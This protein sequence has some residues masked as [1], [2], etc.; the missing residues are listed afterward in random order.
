M[1]RAKSNQ[2][3]IT[4]A[5]QVWGDRF[6]YSQTHYVNGKTKVEI[7]CREHGVFSQFPSSHLNKA[8]GCK[9][10]PIERRR[11]TE[12][13][14]KDAQA[15]WGDRFD[16]SQTH[17]RTVKHK[18]KIICRE[19]GEFWQLAHGHL[20]HHNGCISCRAQAAKKLALTRHQQTNE[21]DGFYHAQ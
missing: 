3:F 12:Q 5:N 10:C 13:F 4:E 18:I 7:I 14:I 6:D 9:L 11:T 19:H 2:Q 17:Y 8:V 16:Y 15:L 21:K 20:Q 1:T